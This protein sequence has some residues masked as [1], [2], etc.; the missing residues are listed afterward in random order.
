MPNCLAQRLCAHCQA[1]LPTGCNP[2]RLYC[3]ANCKS[4]AHARL[5]RHDELGDKRRAYM[6]RWY[7]ANAKR[8][9]GQ[10]RARRARRPELRDAAVERARRWKSDNPDK[11]RATRSRADAKRRTLARNAYV[12]DVDPKYIFERDAYR[13]HICGGKTLRSK[14]APHPRAPTLDHIIPIARGGT[15]ERANLATACHR[16]NARKQAKPIGQPMLFG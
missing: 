2:R 10:E 15:H 13:C 4:L 16:C 1:P 9:R 11:A 8:V 7:A 5:H 6:R 12:E 14:K 3:S